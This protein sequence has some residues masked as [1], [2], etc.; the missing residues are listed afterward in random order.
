MDKKQAQMN[1]TVKRVQGTRD[2]GT[3]YS[4][5]RF[6]TLSKAGKKFDVK[7][8]QEVAPQGLEDDVSYTIV[9]AIYNVDTSTVYRRIWVRGYDDIVPVKNDIIDE[10]L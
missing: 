5:Q 2:D 8:R 1:I 7:F 9:N 3:K 4:F 6:T 10:D